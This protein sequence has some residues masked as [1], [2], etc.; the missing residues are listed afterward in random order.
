MNITD[1]YTL[2]KKSFKYIVAES[3]ELAADSSYWLQMVQ[4]T[5]KL[6]LG[7]NFFAPS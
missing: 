2:T 5:C 3:H 7:K 1:G 4:T 6:Y